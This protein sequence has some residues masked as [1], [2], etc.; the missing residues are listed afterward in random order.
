MHLQQRGFDVSL[1]DRQ[2][3]ATATSF[4]NAGVINDSSF[5]PLNNP[6]L[7]KKL[8]RLLLNNRP[9]L[10]Y[11]YAHVLKNLPW[12]F[13][14]LRY[15]T[16]GKS[17][18][19]ATALASLVADALDE[20]RAIMQRVGNM[21]RLSKSGWLKVYRRDVDNFFTEQDS[22]LF[23]THDV[24]I[25]RLDAKQIQELEPGLKPIFLSLIHI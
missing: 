11:S 3:P 7:I 12:C 16:A 13:N 14:F 19:T 10:R 2:L 1:I 20:H 15:A 9:E 25:Q 22:A 24:G 21:H 4:G 6:G 23:S 8:P 5:I 18:E 17:A